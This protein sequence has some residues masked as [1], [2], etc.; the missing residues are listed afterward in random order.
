MPD[1]LKMWRLVEQTEIQIRR[2]NIIGYL[3]TKN[4]ICK[5][6]EREKV[7]Q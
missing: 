6:N 1:I 5:N 3:G 7:G 4:I 2:D